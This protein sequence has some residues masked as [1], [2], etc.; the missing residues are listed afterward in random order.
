MGAVVMQASVSLD[1]F[2][3]GVAGNVGLLF[4]WYGNGDV[5]LTGAD[6]RRVFHISAA[7]ADFLRNAWGRIKATVSGRTLFDLANGWNGQPPMGDTVFAVTLRAPPSWAVSDAPFIFVTDGLAS[8]VAQAKVFAG[9]QDVGII[10]GNIGGRAF[11]AG[12]STRCAWTSSRSCSV[13]E[14][15]ISATAWALRS[16]W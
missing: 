9:D 8:A 13:P 14:S 10:P 15:G 11:A 7:S 5:A 4:D 1:G 3:A 12:W 2:I 16:S 6:P